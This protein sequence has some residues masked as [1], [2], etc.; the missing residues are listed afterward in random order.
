MN[1]SD[2]IKWVIAALVV[3][4]LMLAVLRA[5]IR[6]AT[7]E[8]RTAVVKSLLDG[9]GGLAVLV[10]LIFT[11]TQLIDSRRES[12]VG[13]RSDRFTAAMQ[14]L[15]EGKAASL[16]ADIVVLGQVARL[17]PET[18]H[19]PV[20]QA[21][22][23][24]IRGSLPRSAPGGRFHPEWSTPGPAAV[25]TP[26]WQELGGPSTAEGTAAELP[27]YEL[28][29]A[30]NVILGRDVAWDRDCIDLRGLDMRTLGSLF[31]NRVISNICFDNS[32][33]E[34][35]VFS[36]SVIEHSSFQSADLDGARFTD[37]TIRCVEFLRADLRRAGF[38]STK[39]KY[40]GL[41][42]ADLTKAEGL[43]EPQ[44]VDADYLQST[45]PAGPW[46]AH[47]Q[48][49][50]VDWPCDERETVDSIASSD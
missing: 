19:D 8:E 17:D 35:A 40:V 45:P 15:S 41:E 26:N 11:W 1:F 14:R 10:G 31:G 47:P 21:L 44:L 42:F 27:I 20:M 29:V 36:N 50:P 2:L 7:T 38:R 18:Y 6:P 49:D 23:A 33:L 28:G 30:L 43:G 37:A 39:F 5:Y 48:T 9:V 34:R 13:E 46:Q 3:M 22:T 16:T 24:Y 4:V 32:I 12:E 25:A